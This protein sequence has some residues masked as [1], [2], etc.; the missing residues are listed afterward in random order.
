MALPAEKEKDKANATSGAEKA[1][2]SEKGKQRK[3]GWEALP[4]R[5]EWTELRLLVLD[6]TP[7]TLHW[8]LRDAPHCNVEAARRARHPSLTVGAGRVCA[9]AL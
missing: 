4:H 7:H 5:S 2:D 8:M 9:L 1:V 6:S 3:R